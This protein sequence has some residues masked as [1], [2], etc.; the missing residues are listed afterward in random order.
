MTH[1]KSTPPPGVEPPL[2]EAV[3]VHRRYGSTVAL[4]D[5]GLRVVAGRSHA[6]VGRNGA[7]KSTL[8]RLLTG[9]ERPDTGEVRLGG[10]PAPPPADRDAWRRAVACVYQRP[11]VVPGLTVAENLFLNRQPTGRLGLVDWR[12][13]RRA[14][15]EL[16]DEWNVEVDVDRQVRELSIE[17]RQLV[18]IARALSFGA[19][20]IV[21]DEPTAQL[22][23]AEIEQLFTRMRRLQEGGVTFLF[24]SHHLREVY[25]VCQDVTV[26]RDARH[27]LTAPVDQLGR[28]DLVAAMTGEA[29]ELGTGLTA[30]R[31]GT[32]EPEVLRLTGFHGDRFAGVDLVVRA[33]EVVGLAGSSASGK[34]ELAESLAGLRV[35]E[36]YLRLGGR[37][38]PTGDVP[39]ALA[40]GVGCVPRDRHEQGLVPELSVAENATMTVTGRLGRA[41]FVSSRSRAAVAARSTEELDVHA[42][43]LDQPV[44]SLSGGNQQKVVTARALATDPRLLVLINPTAGVD[45]KSKESLL[46]ALDRVRAEGTAVVLV[47]DELDDLR[48]CDRVLVLLRG[49]IVAEHPAG[50]RDADLVSSIEG[51]ST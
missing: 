31:G 2:V 14:A 20:F 23:S 43:G 35:A 28:A 24:I 17:D 42:D 19:R 3:A 36:G 25:E 9:L 44:A 39:A 27:V 29:A 32:E 11:T 26:L 49:V 12:R 38:C 30:P 6:L 40:A 1:P 45:V 8:V 18:E 51:I 34:V 16:L 46:D 41:G 21:L 33:G 7:G 13:L 4:D 5:V 48:R 10:R 22:D 15:R 37:I 47:S 50:W